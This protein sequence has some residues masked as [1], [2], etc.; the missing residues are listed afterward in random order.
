M[1]VALD[2]SLTLS[3]CF[4]DEVTQRTEAL[5]DRVRMEGAVVSAIWPLEV[6]NGLLAGQRRGRV[7][8]SKAQGFAEALI[9]L[10]IEIDTSAWSLRPAGALALAR[11]F[12]LTPYDATYLELALRRGLA[13]ACNDDPMRT[14]ARAAGLEVL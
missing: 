6:A 1:A 5:L 10:P 2:A 9:A 3:W 7:T 4:E 8:E 13:L 12:G 11:R 14:A